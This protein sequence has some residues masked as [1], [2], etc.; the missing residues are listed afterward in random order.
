MVTI[1]LLMVWEIACW[2]FGPTQNF[3]LASLAPEASG[4]VLSL[5]STFV[6]FG[7]AA[8]AGIGGVAVGSLSITSITWISAASVVVA[9]VIAVFSFGN[10]RS[11]SGAQR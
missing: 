4:I 1:L 11:F 10:A 3:N 9:V 8:G 7:F 2:T 5:N 6:Q